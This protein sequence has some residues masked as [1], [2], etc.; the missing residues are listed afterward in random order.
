M[1]QNNT[2]DQALLDALERDRQG[3]YMW[4]VPVAGTPSAIVPKPRTRK[5][6]QPRFKRLCL[7]LRNYVRPPTKYCLDCRSI[8]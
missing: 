2:V 4:P 6:P 1:D 8:R 3:L 5:A 7:C